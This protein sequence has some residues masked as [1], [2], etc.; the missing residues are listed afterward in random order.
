MIRIALVLSVGF[1]STSA[2]RADITLIAK[3]S[4]PAS[5]TDKSGL[6]DKLANG[7]PHN[8]LGSSG[9]GIAYT[10]VGNRYILLPDRGPMDGA[11]PFQCRFQVM[12]ITLDPIAGLRLDLADTKILRDR[13]G[14]PFV[15]LSSVLKSG[16]TGHRLDPEGVRVGPAG[17]VYISDEY[18]P[19]LLEFDSSGRW[20]RDLPVPSRF[21]IK[22]P[23]ADPAKEL[24]GN[25][26]GRVPNKGMEGLAITPDGK[27]LVGCMQGALIQDGG[28]KGT[29]VR[30]VETD[31]S[32]KSQREF[33][34]PLEDEKAGVSEILAVNDREF[35]VLERS[36]S[37]DPAT[38]KWARIYKIDISRATDVSGVKSLPAKLL[39]KDVVPATKHQFIDLLDPRYGLGGP[40]FPTK[41]EGITFGP[42]LADG[43]HLL[44]VTSDNDVGGTP[45]Y[46]FGFAIDST[47]LPT[48]QRQEFK[49]AQ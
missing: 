32:T 8:S 39:P 25:K 41:I 20:I 27:K 11:T 24:A 36:G 48:F 46:V 19:H 37:S 40:N 12:D 2:A 34:Y 38:P 28:S 21:Q 18:G 49:A 29:H 10:G 35:L 1:I 26:S 22:H 5:A 3:G 15:G 44:L 30:I 6:T 14:K 42:D 7:I 4:L 13:D 9:S 43:R 31:L 17:Q 16:E 33:V 23:H 47:S 45:T